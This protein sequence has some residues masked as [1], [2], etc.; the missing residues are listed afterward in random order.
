MSNVPSSAILT[1]TGVVAAALIASM[2]FTMSHSQNAA[3]VEANAQAGEINGQI[4]EGRITT[5]D[6]KRIRG[7]EVLAAV[8]YLDNEGI[9]ILVNNGYADT[10]YAYTYN[11]STEELTP[12]GSSSNMLAQAKDRS[13]A[14]AYIS[15]TQM[16][17]GQVIRSDKTGAIMQLRFNADATTST[18]PNPGQGHGG[19]GSTTPVVS[20]DVMVTYHEKNDKGEWVQFSSTRGD[21]NQVFTLSSA[22]PTRYT[23]FE[24]DQWNTKKDGTGT[25]YRAGQTVTLT[26]DI[27]LYAQYNEKTYEVKFDLNMPVNDQKADDRTAFATVTK[28]YHES[29]TIPSKIPVKEGFDF[30]GWSSGSYTYQPGAI[31]S[32]YGKNPLKLTA[33]WTRRVYKVSFDANGGSGS[34]DVEQFYDGQTKSLYSNQFAK[35]GYKFAGWA[36]ERTDDLSKIIYQEQ[37]AAKFTADQ[38]ADSNVTLYAVW[39]QNGVFAVTYDLDGGEWNRDNTESVNEGSRY[40]LASEVPEKAGYRFAGWQEV[41]NG[42]GMGIYDSGCVYDVTEDKTFVALYETTERKYVVE[43]YLQNLDGSYP[44]KP[45][46]REEFVTEKSSVMPMTYSFKGYDAPPLSTITLKTGATTTVKY[47]YPRRKFELSIELTD[48]TSL[49]RENQ[50]EGTYTY[51]QKVTVKADVDRDGGYNWLGWIG[52]EDLEN[53]TVNSQTITFTMPAD[54]VTLKAN[55]EYENYNITYYLHDGTNDPRNPKSFFAFNGV[56]IYKPTKTG[57]TFAAWNGSPVELG[58]TPDKNG[59][60]HV[61]KGTKKDLA[62]EALW[63][64]N[65]YTIRFDKNASDATGKT[66]TMTVRYDVS[67]SLVENGY[68][69]KGYTFTGWNTEADGSGTHYYDKETVRNL[70]AVNN[71]SVTLYA[72]WKANEYE[73]VFHGNGSTGGEMAAA[74]VTYGQ[75]ATLPKNTFTR[76]GYSFSTWNTKPDGLGTSY[77]DGA[78]VD[79][80]ADGTSDTIDLY[81]VWTADKNTKYTVEHYKM[82]V[83]GNYPSTPDSRDVFT[84]VTD[85]MVSPAAKDFGDGFITPAPESAS[86]SGKGDTVIKY[87]YIRKQYTFTLNQA[88]GVD[89][90]GST[91]SGV[92]YYGT[93]VSINAS[94]QKG[95]DEA[96]FYFDVD[97]TKNT[98]RSFTK[99]LTA[100]TVV[101]PHVGKITYTITYDANGGT[102]NSGNPDTYTVTDNYQLLDASRKGYE[103]TGWRDAEGRTWSKIDIG[104]TGDISLKAGWKALQGTSYKVEHY[105]MDLDGK[106]YRLTETQYMAGVTDDTIPDWKKTYEGF[107][108]ASKSGDTVIKADGTSV[109]RYNYSRNKHT[110]TVSTKGAV[111]TSESAKTGSYYYGQE[112]K[113]AADAPEGWVWDGWDDGNTFKVRTITMPDK[114]MSL[115]AKAYL[116]R[117]TISYIL[118]GGQKDLGHWDDK[119]AAADPRK[120]GHPESYDSSELPLLLQNPV[121]DGYLFDGWTGSNSSRTL[122]KDYVVPK[123]MTGNLSYIANWSPIDYTVRFNA[124]GGTG[125]MEDQVYTYDDSLGTALRKNTFTRNGYK[126]MGWNDKADGTGKSY[127]DCEPLLFNLTTVNKSTVTLYAVWEGNTPAEIVEPKWDSNVPHGIKP[128]VSLDKDPYLHSNVSWTGWAVIRVTIPRFTGVVNGKSDTCDVVTLQGLNSNFKLLKEYNEGNAHILYYGYKTPLAG[129][130][131]TQEL[132]TSIKAQNFSALNVTEDDELIVGVKGFILGKSDRA[133]RTTDTYKYYNTIDEAFNT[134]FIR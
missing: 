3:G 102:N 122:M 66:N 14:N 112:V 107:S 126:F 2:A 63:S 32:E 37:D 12:T 73:V 101:T 79:S 43:H 121:C 64:I 69:R 48:G 71:G 95:Y 22:K 19:G 120:P 98:N 125:S 134:G 96:G 113:I 85:T 75:T 92:Y 26:G 97:G 5:Y 70:T 129:F 11:S 25:Y 42:K 23:G 83:N 76:D 49:S 57:Y 50:N 103:F 133:D 119:A 35:S 108:Y 84:A 15:P 77:A 118:G 34:M 51:G 31:V 116:V 88:E 13:N 59:V 30:A 1:V 62:F 91:Q 44:S 93:T 46:K 80:L 87:Y 54:D 39:K 115:T 106:T 114:D 82:N 74:T 16:Y 8:E 68:A 86:V 100:N 9:S 29:V 56:D 55:A 24:F 117:Y 90:S 78:K 33:V 131:S 94:V 104:T 123:G 72:Q 41:E 60:I 7:S 128:N 105:Q 124:N 17:V 132:F 27:D 4:E 40:Y 67:A 81:A 45:E 6:G 53:V 89:I 28:L 65:Q 47:N 110:F 58:L 130:A 21:K 36:L 99:T 52:T 10:Q 109:L 20:Q 61:A 18:N 38:F 127:D 111:L